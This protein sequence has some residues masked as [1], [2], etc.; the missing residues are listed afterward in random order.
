MIIFRDDE[1]GIGGWDPRV[2][3]IFSI[4]DY[5][6]LYF[7]GVPLTFL[8]ATK[9]IE[10]LPSWLSFFLSM[11]LWISGAFLIVLGPFLLFYLIYKGWQNIDKE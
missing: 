8:L 9:S 1:H 7:K 5:L 10:H 2:V 6:F 3:L 11:F 4:I